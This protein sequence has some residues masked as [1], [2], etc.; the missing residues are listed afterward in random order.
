MALVTKL[1]NSSVMVGVIPSTRRRRYQQIRPLATVLAVPYTEGTIDG[2][3]PVHISWNARRSALVS[4][5]NEWLTT[6]TQ[7]RP[8]MDLY[9][10]TTTQ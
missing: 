6:S 3:I 9:G 8:I 1:A 7:P 10:S 2:V 4:F 5:F